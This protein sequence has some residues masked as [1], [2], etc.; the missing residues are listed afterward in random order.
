MEEKSMLFSY[1]KSQIPP[2]APDY[3]SNPFLQGSTTLKK[4]APRSSV[5]GC[6]SAAS[7]SFLQFVVV[8]ACWLR[9]LQQGCI[10]SFLISLLYHFADSHNWYVLEVPTGK[11]PIISCCCP[12]SPGNLRAAGVV[13]GPDGSCGHMLAEIM[14]TIIFTVMSQLLLF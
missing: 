14:A 5:D 1:L 12:F 4:D 7:L 9:K 13:R 11:A 2:H 10:H 3:F 8:A 6:I